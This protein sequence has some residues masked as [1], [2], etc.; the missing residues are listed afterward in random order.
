M[1]R[2]SHS[3]IIPNFVMFSASFSNYPANQAPP[4]TQPPEITQNNKNEPK[5][6]KISSLIA[7]ETYR[8]ISNRKYLRII[9]YDPFH[10]ARV[11]RLFRKL[12][13]INF[14]IVISMTALLI[15]CGE[16]KPAGVNNVSPSKGSGDGGGTE[17]GTEERSPEDIQNYVD[18]SFIKAHYKV[19]ANVLGMGVCNGE[20]DIS[21]DPALG[22]T[23][24]LLD[25]QGGMS[26]MGQEL[27]FAQM[28][29]SGAEPP[30]TAIA[31]HVM[32][33]EAM[34]PILFQPARPFFPIFIATQKKDL[35]NLSVSRNLQMQN[36]ATGEAGIGTIAVNVTEFEA[37]YQPPPMVRTFKNCLRYNA[38]TTGFDTVKDKFTNFLFDKIEMVISLDPIAIP[39]ILFQGKVADAMAAQNAQG[40]G[41][42][43][44]GDLLGGGGA[45]G[46]TDLIPGGGIIKSLIPILTDMV[47]VKVEFEMMSMEGV[48]DSSYNS[49]DADIEEQLSNGDN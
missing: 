39:Y 28:I 34:G 25:I 26:C 37:A 42:G 33:F 5:S 2:H 16:K 3:S 38:T 46:I 48:S 43:G 9:L 1:L 27:D 45:G 15:S 10:W 24:K 47:D 44:L 41:G 18:G 35:R 31:D 49:D 13:K 19:T 29:G 12:T 22:A 23:G 20:V 11:F 30:K 8:R 4:D 32:G 40:G 6:L 17:A 36:Q 14:S 7:D 21:I